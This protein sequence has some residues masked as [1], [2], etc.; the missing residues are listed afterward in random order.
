MGGLDVTV[1]GEHCAKVQPICVLILVH[2]CDCT[3]LSEAWM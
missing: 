1:C 3:N 2:K